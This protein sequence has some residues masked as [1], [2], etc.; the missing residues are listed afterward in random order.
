MTT[1]TQI[2]GYSKFSHNGR[3]K[4]K[5]SLVATGSVPNNVGVTCF[6]CYV[7]EEYLRSLEISVDDL[8]G[9][10]CHVFIKDKKVNVTFKNYERS[11]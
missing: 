6:V 8:L 5:L 1:R 2:V 11:N 4:I 7:N 10:Y 3:N 9:I